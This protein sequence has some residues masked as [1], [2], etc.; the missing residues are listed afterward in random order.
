MFYTIR[1]YLSNK[2]CFFCQHLLMFYIQGDF[3]VDVMDQKLQDTKKVTSYKSFV[4][5]QL[6]FETFPQDVYFKGYNALII[7]LCYVLRLFTSG[8]EVECCDKF[9]VSILA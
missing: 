8:N 6:L 3:Q 4:Q 5:F 1:L 9:S 2:K 7:Q